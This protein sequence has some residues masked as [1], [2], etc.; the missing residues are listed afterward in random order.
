ML[1]FERLIR[2]IYE[3]SFHRKRGDLQL[4]DPEFEHHVDINLIK[5]YTTAMCYLKNKQDAEDVTQNVFL[6]LYTHSDNF[7]DDDHIRAWLLRCT[8][9]ECKDLLRSHW[10]KFS[11]P[12]EAA[13]DKVYNEQSNEN[14]RLLRIMQKLNKNNRIVLYL[15]YYEEYSCSEISKIIGISED[16]VSARLIRGRKQLKKL[17]E[18]KRGLNYNE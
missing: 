7:I 12:L 6:K 16:A 9:N 1:D 2:Y 4:T 13:D 18:N 17:I 8:I 10:Y 15:Y 5:V 14:D 3:R 11:E